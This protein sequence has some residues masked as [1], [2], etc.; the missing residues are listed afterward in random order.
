MLGLLLIYY[1]GKTFADLAETYNHSRWGF[2]ILGVVTYYAGTF[3]SGII[4]YILFDLFESTFIED[5]NEHVL[6]ILVLPFGLLLCWGVHQFLKRQW[7]RKKVLEVP[8]ILDAE[9]IE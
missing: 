6:G 9:W 1:I 8:D 3:I 4:L 5:M 2:A 7:T